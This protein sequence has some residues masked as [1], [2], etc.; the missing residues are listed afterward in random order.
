MEPIGSLLLWDAGWYLRISHWIHCRVFTLMLQKANL[1]KNLYSSHTSIIRVLLRGFTRWNNVTYTSWSICLKTFKRSKCLPNIHSRHL[2][3]HL[4][5]E[6]HECHGSRSYSLA[7][8]IERSNLKFKDN[9]EKRI[10]EQ[11]RKLT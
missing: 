1:I 8:V 9:I 6:A 7:L 3:L 4:P 2:L 5:R 11:E 10:V